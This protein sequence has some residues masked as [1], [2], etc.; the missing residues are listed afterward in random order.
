[1]LHARYTSKGAERRTKILQQRESGNYTDHCYAL[2]FEIPVSNAIDLS[3]RIGAEAYRSE[4]GEPLWTVLSEIHNLEA[5][6]WRHPRIFRLG[7]PIGKL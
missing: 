5:Y 3:M 2:G 4:I 7:K 6:H 1:L